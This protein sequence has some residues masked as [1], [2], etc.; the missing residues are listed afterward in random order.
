[1][2]NS[3]QKHTQHNFD[4]RAAGAIRQDVKQCCFQNF[5]VRSSD[6]DLKFPGTGKTKS[7]FTQTLSLMH[8]SIPSAKG[9]TPGEFFEVVKNPAPEQ[10]FSAKAR[11]PG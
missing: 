10:N 6:P 4:K 9:Q 1:M 5:P 8:Q 7:R 2:W 3:F 11:P